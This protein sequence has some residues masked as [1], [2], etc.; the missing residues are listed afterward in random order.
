MEMG[1]ET[2]PLQ[3]QSY[4]EDGT[5]HD[6]YRW[7]VPLD[8]ILAWAVDDSLPELEKEVVEEDDVVEEIPVVQKRDEAGKIHTIPSAKDAFA[9][10]KYLVKWQ[11]ES[12]RRIAWVPHAFLMAAYPAK[13]TNFLAKGSLVSFELPPIEDEPEDGEEDKVVPLGSAPLPDPNARDRIPKS[14]STVDRVLNVWYISKKANSTQP[15][16]WKNYRKLP[17]DPMESIRLIVS[18]H[19]KWGELPYGQ[20]EFIVSEAHDE[21]HSLTL[22]CPTQQRSRSR[23]KRAMTAMMNMSRR[24]KTS[25]RPTLQL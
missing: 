19:F 6:C 18:C 4:F 20:C 10:A 3:V 24:T 8:V 1:G 12:Y 13:L 16:E 14:W 22:V 15:V 21:A 17:E 7:D 2:Y 5:C 11:G 9:R 23:L 25:W